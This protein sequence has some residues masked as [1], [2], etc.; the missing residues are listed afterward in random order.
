MD[1]LGGDALLRCFKEEADV[2]RGGEA[3]PS[4]EDANLS[5]PGFFKEVFRGLL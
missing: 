4:N 3:V 2:G 1:D 5:L